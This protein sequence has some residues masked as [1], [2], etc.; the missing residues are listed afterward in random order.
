MLVSMIA[1]I[2]VEMDE[3]ELNKNEGIALDAIKDIKEGKLSMFSNGERLTKS[4]DITEDLKNIL[5][6][7]KIEA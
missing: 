6:H 1:K 2:V 4:E 3:A 7:R 5:L